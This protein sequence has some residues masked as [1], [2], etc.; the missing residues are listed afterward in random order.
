MIFTMTKHLSGTLALPDQDFLWGAQAIA[1]FL[2]LTERQVFHHAERGTLPI[3]KVANRLFA[4]RSTL[5]EFLN[6]KIQNGEFN[7]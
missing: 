2:G 1:Q 7:K 3:G 6:S 4:R 5:E